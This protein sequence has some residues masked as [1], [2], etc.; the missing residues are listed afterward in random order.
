MNAVSASTWIAESMS[1][2]VSTAPAEAAAYDGQGGSTTTLTTRNVESSGQFTVPA[3]AIA[4]S[5]PAEP[6]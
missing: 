1:L 4:R 3:R 2:Q 5:A 6:S